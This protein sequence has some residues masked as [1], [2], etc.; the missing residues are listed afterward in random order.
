MRGSKLMLVNYMCM[1]L[2]G[3]TLFLHLA[4][5]AFLGV[6]GYGASLEPDAVKGHYTDTATAFMLAVLLVVLAFHSIFSFKTTLLEWRH[7]KTWTK[8]VNWGAIVVAAV[9]VAFGMWTIVAAYIT[10]W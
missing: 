9:M 1:V 7:G 2:I 5:H 8:A 10:R 4:T 6:S 3:I